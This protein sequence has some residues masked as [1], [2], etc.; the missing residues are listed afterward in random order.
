[1]TSASIKQLWSIRNVVD[2]NYP[3]PLKR[4]IQININQI[5]YLYSHLIGQPQQITP[6]VIAL[7]PI[8]LTNNIQ[9]PN[10]IFQG[11]YIDGV[12]AKELLTIYNYINGKYMLSSIQTTK[13]GQEYLNDHPISNQ[14]EQ[15]LLTFPFP[16][17]NEF[18][19]NVLETEIPIIW[20][21]RFF[22]EI[23]LTQ[24]GQVF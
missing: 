7:K 9:K 20:Q 12:G 16:N 6:I 3:T 14:Y 13:E 21:S 2:F 18:K 22:D 8:T 24:I 5:I 23:W 10:R 4:Q 1:M 11:Y 19:E 15:A 17:L